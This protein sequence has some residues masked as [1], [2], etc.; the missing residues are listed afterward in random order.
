MC[1]R[2]EGMTSISD[3]WEDATTADG[4]RIEIDVDPYMA[5]YHG[6]PFVVK[7]DGCEVAV[8]SV[9]R[10][11]DGGTTMIR[12]SAGKITCPRQLGSTDRTPRLKP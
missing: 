5:D 6:E 10:L 11:R 2:L 9:A 3:L 8:H 7:V 12:T 1:A 4:H